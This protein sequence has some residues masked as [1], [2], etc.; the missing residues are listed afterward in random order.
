M[1]K[2]NDDGKFGY[3]KEKPGSVL[4]IG[5]N[6]VFTRVRYYPK[7]QACTGSLR[8]YPLW[9]RCDY[10]TITMRT[11]SKIFIS[12]FHEGKILTNFVF[13]VVDPST[14]LENLNFTLIPKFQK[15]ICILEYSQSII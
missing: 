4:C 11:V 14:V 13:I 10:C 12:P 7:F 5:K 3:A 15:E 2:S 9:I 1:H 6:V 8:M